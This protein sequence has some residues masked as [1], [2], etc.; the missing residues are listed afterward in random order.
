MNIAAID[1]EAGFPDE[2]RRATT[3]KFAAV[4]ILAVLVMAALTLA[5]VI[6]SRHNR[7]PY[8][9]ATVGA[10]VRMEVVAPGRAQ[11]VVDRL[12]GP[13]RLSVPVVESAKGQ[14][15][16]QQVVG[17][18]TFRTPHNAPGGGQYALFIIDRALGQ[19]VSA[20]YA[21]GPVGTDVTQG[22]DGKY[23]EVAAKYPWLHMLASTPT[24]DGSGFTNPGMAVS[25]APNTPS[26]VTFTAVL[27]PRS[28]PVTDPSR[29]L[30]VALAFIGANGH[31]HWATK[32][33]G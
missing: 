33:A 1:R 5:S 29:Q 28:L 16:Q 10:S 2:T 31:I 6:A 15:T 12:A 23:D 19:P 14:P 22:W 18:L 9:A 26:P 20:V 7:A 4:G 30:T 11:A 13:G 24:A 17:Q 21:T 32:L 25:F 3:R 27:D 8:A